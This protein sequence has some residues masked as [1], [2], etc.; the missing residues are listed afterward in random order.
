MQRYF[1]HLAYNGSN[2][3]GW[4][5]QPNA[6]SVQE[7]LENCLSTLLRKPIEII[8]AGR[9]DSGVHAKEMYAHF[10]FE[11][12]LSEDLVKK[13]N[14]YLSADIVI[15]D[16]INVNIEA[17]ARF[18]ASSRTYEYHIH[19]KKDPFLT[20]HSY[21]VK[22]TLN[23]EAMREASIILLKYDDFECF[24]KVH[25]DVNTFICQISEIHWQAI[26]HRLIFT[27][28][29]NR[30]LRNMVRAIVGTLLEVGLGKLQV[31]DMH[32]IIQSKN[33]GQAGFSVPAHGLFLTKVKYPYL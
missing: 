16:I 2:Y 11:N 31:D 9:T 12:Q 27:I 15:F 18:D 26:E 22:H 5:R 32:C 10:D 3:H 8:G 30:F 23:L 1:I 33:R 7:V 24:S 14:S 19:T 17:H 28:S 21:L 13:M 4:Q 6:L 25:T 20:S 29:A